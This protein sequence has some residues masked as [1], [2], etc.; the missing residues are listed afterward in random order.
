MNSL[1]LPCRWRFESVYD[2]P[3][4][5][6]IWLLH[7]NIKYNINIPYSVEQ[8]EVN[9]HPKEMWPHMFALR[10]LTQ[11]KK[12]T[13]LVFLLQPILKMLKFSVFQEKPRF[14]SKHS[15]NKAQA[16]FVVLHLWSTPHTTVSAG[17]MKTEEYNKDQEL[18]SYVE[19]L[20]K[21]IQEKR[22]YSNI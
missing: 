4:W 14:L 15:H 20:I 9:K 10:L 6:Q 21:H 5:K 13:L 18:K 17:R 2:R 11:E 16:V 12:D 22:K 7:F 3:M 1:L 8:K 19:E